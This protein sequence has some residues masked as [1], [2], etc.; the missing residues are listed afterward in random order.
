M[1]KAKTRRIECGPSTVTC[2]DWLELIVQGYYVQGASVALHADFR[3]NK[4]LAMNRRCLE[5]RTD[6][7]SRRAAHASKTTQQSPMQALPA[8]Y[9]D[10][11]KYAPLDA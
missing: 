7:E 10:R 3:T 6:P 2:G 9:T 1:S 4:Q 8:L 5:S 11:K